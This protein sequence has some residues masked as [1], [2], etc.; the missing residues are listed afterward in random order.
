MLTSRRAVV[1]QGAMYALSVGGASSGL[2]VSACTFSDL[3]G[4]AVKLGN[5][6]D[7][8]AVSKDPA[9]WDYDMTLEQVGGTCGGCRAHAQDLT[10]R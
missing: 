4:G 5:V 8:R 2:A 10:T 3:S 9:A 7:T 6:N 1:L